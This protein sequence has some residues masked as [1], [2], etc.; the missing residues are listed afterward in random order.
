MQQAGRLTQTSAKQ[1]LQEMVLHGQSARQVCVDKHLGRIVDETSLDALVDQVITD[2]A[3]AARQFQLG[4]DAVLRFLVGAVVKASHGTADPT[5]AA[6]CLKRR[7][8]Q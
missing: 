5:T 8:R 3:D 7:L 1:A 4:K 2:N 6:D